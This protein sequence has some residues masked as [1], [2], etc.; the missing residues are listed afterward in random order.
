MFLVKKFFYSSEKPFYIIANI[1]Y[2][3]KSIVQIDQG[4]PLEERT[5][6]TSLPEKK[7]CTEVF[8]ENKATWTKILLKNNNNL[9]RIHRSPDWCNDVFD[10]AEKGF[11]A[12]KTA[13]GRL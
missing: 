13:G 8:T 7:K 1:T 6:Q 3:T 2:V 11:W 9:T 5:K 10:E 4:A 12:N